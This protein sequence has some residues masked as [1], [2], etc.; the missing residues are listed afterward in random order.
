MGRDL[1]SS[2]VVCGLWFYMADFD[3][4]IWFQAQRARVVVCT[5]VGLGTIK[6]IIYHCRKSTRS[7]GQS[8]TIAQS[9]L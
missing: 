9:F 1:E 2:I 7:K 4:R 3:I 5:T 6:K 8:A